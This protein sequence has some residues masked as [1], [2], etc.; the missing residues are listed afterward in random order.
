MLGIDHLCTSCRQI[1]LNWKIST[2]LHN[3]SI[4]NKHLK[5]YKNNH[6]HCNTTS[7]PPPPRP[8]VPGVVGRPSVYDSS[9][10]VGEG[11]IY[12]IV[13]YASKNKSSAYLMDSRFGLPKTSL[14]AVTDLTELLSKT[15]T[16]TSFKTTGSFVGFIVFDRC[17]L[18][19][20]GQP[21]KIMNLLVLKEHDTCNYNVDILC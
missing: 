2:Y 12:D 4:N 16:M 10:L 8:L 18:R 6:F 17:R 20:F 15:I 1:H 7:S 3:T 11:R 14:R 21:N 13:P 19:D 9:F 5:G